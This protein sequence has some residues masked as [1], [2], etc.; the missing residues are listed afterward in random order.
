MSMAAH[1]V[2]G[3]FV[4]VYDVKNIKQSVKN[5]LLTQHYEKPFHPEIG[6]PLNG[7]LFEPMN[8]NTISAIKSTIEDMLGAYETRIEVTQIDVHADETDNAYEVYLQ[9][10]IK[11]TIEPVEFGFI[12]QRTA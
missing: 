4:R 11:N 2:T 6:S 12:L 7:L 1:P 5:L 10:R 8:I 9:F 3:D